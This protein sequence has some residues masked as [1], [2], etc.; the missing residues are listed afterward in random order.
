V[1]GMVKI[2]R[3]MGGGGYYIHCVEFHGAKKRSRKSDL[4]GWRS[5]T[6]TF[7]E[8]EQHQFE[9]D[10]GIP[11]STPTGGGGKDEEWESQK[12]L[13]KVRKLKVG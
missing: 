4:A 7:G 10:T 13:S 1:W 5:T 12:R 9:Y 2:E 8:R 6:G 11:R 3:V